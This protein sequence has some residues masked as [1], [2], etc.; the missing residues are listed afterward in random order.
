M[1]DSTTD[2]PTP[3]GDG[4][5]RRSPAEVA[6][7]ERTA[8]VLAE[9]E[10][11]LAGLAPAIGS[12]AA[13]GTT[14]ASVILSGLWNS[15]SQALPQVFSLIISIAAARFLGPGGMGRQSFIAFTMI[16]LTQ[17]VSE[18]LKESLMRSVG[19]ALGADRPGAVLGLAR[20]ARPILLFGGLAGAAVLGTAGLLGAGPTAAW[21]LAGV[22]C[23]LVAVQGVPWA[24]LIGAQRW[25]Q[26][27]MVGLLT[28]LFGVPVTV[29]VLAAGGGITGMF[30][31]EAA[32]AGVALIAIVTLERRALRELPRDF[33]AAPDLRRRTSRYAVLATLM[34]LA[35][36]VV[37]QRSEFFFLR[38][39]STDRE[40]AFYSI[41]FA[42]AN[43]LALLPGA[44][45]GTLS[46]AFA[47]LYGARHHARIRSGYWRAQRLLP[48][49]SLPLLAGSLALGPAAIRLA[50]GPSYGPAGP[51]LLVLLSLF[52]LIPLLAVATSLLIG[53][54]LLRVALICDA[55]G[56]AVTIGLNFL[57]VPAHAALGAAVADIGGQ[58]VVAIPVLVYAGRLVAPS[59][60][61]V[62][63]AAR[64]VV[65]AAPTGVAAWV[66]DSALG[67]AAGLAVGVLAGV[68]VF[69]ALAAL[70]HPVPEEDR[71]WVHTLLVSRLGGPGGRLLGR[72]AGEAPAATGDASAR[73]RGG[74]GPAGP[75]CGRLVVYSVGLPRGGAARALG[76]LIGALDERV[77]VTVVGVA[78]D[79][80]SWIAAQ[81]PE[82]G[83]LVVPPVAHK[84]QLRPILAQLR[85]I[86]RLRPDVLHASL[87]SPWSC[88]YG[89]LAGLLSPGTRVVAVENAPVPSSRP[90]QRAI[91]RAIS[92]RLAAH[93]AVGEC[94]A[95][96]I[97]RLI[98]LRDGSLVTIRNGVP[99]L[100]R[101][102]GSSRS[103]GATIGDGSIG[104]GP[105][106]GAI[107]RIGPQKGIGLIVRALAELPGVKAVIVGDGP[108][109]AEV[110]ALARGLGVADRLRTPGF[111]PDP[112]WRLGTFDM[113]V[114]PT[115]TEA[116]LPLA[117]IEAMLA[118]LPVVAT[119]IGSISESFLEGE[120][121]LLVPPDDLEALTRALQ[122]LTE[123][124]ALRRRMGARAR[125]YA[126]ERFG[127]TAMARAYEGL[128]R[129]ALAGRGEGAR[130]RR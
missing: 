109:L 12:K 119:R 39:Y 31:V 26:A 125:T 80:V 87:S 102:S 72:L 52:P 28:G 60:F 6:A 41:A 118:E 88:Q 20:W 70:L 37:W 38:A 91:K 19:E 123:D 29:G 130:R 16:S 128:Y 18:G 9:S 3:T 30:A 35:T 112:R 33:E 124:P 46:P 117:I 10:Q 21:L 68:A 115:E 113:F 66:V 111:D 77:E 25:R 22:E 98:G 84:L 103:D 92:R 13:A 63:A 49:V 45:A 51:V 47:T 95:R 120:T 59:A 126:L 55:L 90:L 64:A 56:G 50:Y 27:S 5:S 40:I 81:R 107:S 67:G 78:P 42:A 105:T 1:N 8:G 14:G 32:T 69:L 97:E 85:A 110:Q 114:L 76:Y 96:E 11:A 83:E 54:G 61:D 65:A 82:A 36:F 58:A 4:S 122:Q 23:L 79:T 129:E 53:L 34:T 43:G 71:E 75:P 44:L 106:I 57:L 93:V 127:V 2:R 104:D 94:S 73:T 86:R 74:E 62:P 89:I 99:D 17:V 101:A 121:G 48:I 15:L 24:V 108:V 7:R 116:A 100:P